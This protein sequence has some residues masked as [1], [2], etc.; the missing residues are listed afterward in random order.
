[1]R[2]WMSP[3]IKFDLKFTD[4]IPHTPTIKQ[5]AFLM[6]NHR[7][8]FFGGCGGGGKSDALLMGAL[9]Y[10]DIR[11]FAAI[12]FR[13]TLTNLKLPG[14]LIPRAHEWL[15]SSDVKWDG[16]ENTFLFPKTNAR[17]TFGYLSDV[18]QGTQKYRYSS[19]EFQY[20]AFDELTEFFEDDF[21]FLFSRL[22]RTRCPFHE[23]RKFDGRNAPRPR[24]PNCHT[25]QEYAAL[26]KVP[27]RVRTA[28]NPGNIGH[29]WVKKRYRIDKWELDRNEDGTK[30][31][32][33]N[34]DGKLLFK[35]HH[36]ERPFIP[37]YLT[38]NPYL[39][40]E[41]YRA[42]L[43]NLDPV[44]REQ[45]EHGDWSVSASGRIQEKFFKRYRITGPYVHL[46]KQ[47]YE[48]ADLT[49]FVIMDPA[50]S[51]RDS[52]GEVSSGTNATSFT[53]IG[54]FLLTPKYDLIW[55]DNWRFKE[56][57]DE[58]YQ[59]LKKVNQLHKP[60][61]LGMEVSPISMH[62]YQ[63]FVN[64]GLPMRQFTHE[65][66]DKLS[67][68]TPAINLAQQGRVWL[69]LDA[70]WLDDLESELFIWTGD[71]REPDDQIDVFG[72]AGLYRNEAAAASYSDS[73]VP[74]AMLAAQMTPRFIPRR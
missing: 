24:D 58:I 71:P 6:L 65:G 59:A 41:E 70:P 15:A 36:P 49:R 30:N 64:A 13:K 9:Q 16:Q 2:L 28:A 5:A 52:P 29:M 61:F 26:S 68:A 37:S 63:L 55:W 20:I 18:H 23:G 40:Q 33:K 32:K 60:E 43:Q 74:S 54:T 19:A 25:C 69:P 39:D 22:R 14:G 4:Y 57:V 35:G 38:D 73:I 10:V 7:E 34:W 27:L 50:A 42:S 51:S 31:Y 62:L 66:R 3:V 17:I 47:T 67:R 56:E 1:M 44:T 8:A 11:N 48:H 12:I 21:T 53:V 46:D 45:L 72:Y